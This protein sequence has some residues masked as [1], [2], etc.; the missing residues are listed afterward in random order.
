[1]VKVLFHAQYGS[2][3]HEIFTP[4][5][6]DRHSEH[7]YSYLWMRKRRHCEILLPKQ[8]SVVRGHGVIECLAPN[9]QTLIPPYL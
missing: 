5:I 9:H 8:N 6:L 2:G 7:L 4:I 3:T 1:M